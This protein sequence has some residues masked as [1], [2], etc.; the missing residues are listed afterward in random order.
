[1]E[2]WDDGRVKLYLTHLLLAFR[3]ENRELFQEGDYLPLEVSG[4][5][6]EHIVAFARRH[7]GA[8]TIVIVPR[9]WGTLLWGEGA[10]LPDGGLWTGTTARLPDPAL[11]GRYRN[12]LG[13][14]D[15]IEVGEDGIRL[16]R[17]L[18]GFPVAVLARRP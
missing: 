1:M 11:A 10:R 14:G 12:L 8:T 18:A 3:R 5:R 6:A 13:G 2:K 4:A 7:G 16:E 15:E 9:L 17:A